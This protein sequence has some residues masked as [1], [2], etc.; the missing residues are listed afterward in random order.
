M[1][2]ILF[3]F[4]RVDSSV[5]LMEVLFERNSLGEFLK[6]TVIPPNVLSVEEDGEN[7]IC[8]FRAEL[9]ATISRLCVQFC[10][11]SFIS[12][13]TFKTQT[14]LFIAWLHHSFFVKL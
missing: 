3:Y 14:L 4:K 7:R 2:F 11:L 8:L 13:W 6:I 12:F 1:H 10:H 9:D 5:S